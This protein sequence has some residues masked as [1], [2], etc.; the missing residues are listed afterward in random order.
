MNQ[1]SSIPFGSDAEVIG[2][3]ALAGND[4]L[5]NFDLVIDLPVT[6]NTNSLYLRIKEHDGVTAPSGWKDIA[7][8][9]TV[10]PGGTK[11]VSLVVLN[12]RIGFFG[13]GNVTANISTVQRNKAALGGGQIDIV[14]V[15]RRGW[16]FEDGMDVDSFRP[17]WPTLPNS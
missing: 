16:G 3:Y 10:V 17:N 2:G 12:K 15:A 4:R 14:Q 7:A 5:G 11:T 1:L 13:S 9:I 8:P 6:E